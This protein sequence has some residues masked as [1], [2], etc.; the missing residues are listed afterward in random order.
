MANAQ[1]GGH[2]LQKTLAMAAHFL[3]FQLLNIP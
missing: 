2:E 3:R 1:V